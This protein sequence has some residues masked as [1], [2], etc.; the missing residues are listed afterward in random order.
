MRGALGGYVGGAPRFPPRTGTPPSAGSRGSPTAAEA[1]LGFGVSVP[2]A[3]PPS[4]EGVDALGGAAGDDGAA[5]ASF[6]TCCCVC[7]V[8]Y[9]QTDMWRCSYSYTRF[10]CCNS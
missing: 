6:Y 8:L 10:R 2:G 1:A 5:E 4:E 7:L 9:L 3:F